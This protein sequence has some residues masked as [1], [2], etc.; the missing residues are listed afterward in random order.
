MADLLRGRLSYVKNIKY[1]T[2]YIK[3]QTIISYMQNK[4]VTNLFIF[5]TRILLDCIPPNESQ[6]FYLCI[7]KKP[8]FSI[9]IIFMFLR[10]YLNI[11]EH[12]ISVSLTSQGNYAILYIIFSTDKGG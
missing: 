7:I 1:F 5:L 9:N 4:K 6:V 10:N 12:I 3:Y 8:F 2:F 11:S